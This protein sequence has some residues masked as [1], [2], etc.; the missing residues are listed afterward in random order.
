MLH[1]VRFWLDRGTDGFRLDA[2][3]WIGQDV[4]WPDN[5]T[6]WR[7][8]FRSYLRQLHRYDRDQ[9]L[10][11][12]VLHAIRAVIDRYPG[13]V[14]VGEASADTPGGPAVFYGNGQD[15]LHLVFNF[16]L[17][18][19]RWDVHRMRRIIDEWDRAVSPVGWPT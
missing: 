16:Q 3:N 18:K 5:P 8:R 4:Q 11:H 1:V 9:P 17:L 6:S 19:S 13:V 14:L 10:T 7:P 12:E 2:I 15:E